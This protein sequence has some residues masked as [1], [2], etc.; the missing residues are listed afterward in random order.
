MNVYQEAKLKDMAQGM[1]EQA[2]ASTQGCC[3]KQGN[4]AMPTL[5]ERLRKQREYA[6]GQVDTAMK[7]TELE[8]LLNANPDVA[9][10]LELLE[11]VKY[12]G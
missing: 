12:P 9:R 11:Q 6:E 4:L 10:I 2:Q 5:R 1:M 7:L 3:G 8:H